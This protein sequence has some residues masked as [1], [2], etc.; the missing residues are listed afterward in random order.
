MVAEQTSVEQLELRLEE[1]A[2][3]VSELTAQLTNERSAAEKRGHD[4]VEMMGRLMDKV[5]DI[6]SRGRGESSGQRPPP[7]AGGAAEGANASPKSSDGS[8]EGESAA[9][10]GGSSVDQPGRRGSTGGLGPIVLARG[11]RTVQQKGV[12][13]EGDPRI[14][15]LE[16]REPPAVG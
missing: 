11:P 9:A 8:R 3:A 16:I 4:L 13:P 10:E 12:Q 2:A 7:T 15:T 1:Q 14:G 5:S 6:D